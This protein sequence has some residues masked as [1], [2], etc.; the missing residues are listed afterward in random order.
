VVTLVQKVRGEDVVIWNPG[1][2][3]ATDD[4]DAR[5]AAQQRLMRQRESIKRLADASPPR[6]AVRRLTS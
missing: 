5:A 3:L 6:F 1:P 2:L 4:E